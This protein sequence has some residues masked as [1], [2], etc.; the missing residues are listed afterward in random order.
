MFVWTASYFYVVDTNRTVT[1]TG[2]ARQIYGSTSTKGLKQV[3]TTTQ[4]I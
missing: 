3:Y 4:E 2:Y 1:V